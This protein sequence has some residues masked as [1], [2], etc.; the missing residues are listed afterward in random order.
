MIALRKL[1]ILFAVMACLTSI[2]F[3]AAAQRVMTPQERFNRCI[4][5]CNNLEH[6]C[7]YYGARQPVCFQGFLRCER[8]CHLTGRP[9]R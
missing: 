7:R 3:E 2:S 1:A 8:S 5:T 6:N 4:D 9:S